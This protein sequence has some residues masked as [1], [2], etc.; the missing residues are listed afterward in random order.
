MS[1]VRQ[2]HK[3]RLGQQPEWA[4][5]EPNAVVS[6]TFISTLLKEDNAYSLLHRGYCLVE[7]SEETTACYS[8]F[9]G[10]IKQFF[11]AKDAE[12][13]KYAV[14]Q[15]DPA[16]GSPNQ[17]HGYSRVSTLKEQFMMRCIGTQIDDGYSFPSASFGRFGMQIYQILDLKSRALAKETLAMMGKC[18]KSVD[19]VLDP[20]HEI[21]PNLRDNIVE[22]ENGVFSK[23]VAD[24]YISSS[25]MDNFHYFPPSQAKHERFH[26]NHSSHTDSGLMTAVIVTD[27]PGLEVF[28]QRTSQWIAIE[29]EVIRHLKASGQLKEH[30]LC[31]RQYA[32]FF[33][34]D[35]VQYLNEAPYQ[36]GEER[37]SKTLKP[38]FHRV[39][40]CKQ[41]RYSVVF[42]QRT[43]PLRTHCRY[44]ED[45][46]LASIQQKVDTQS[47][48]AH[49]LWKQSNVEKA[50]GSRGYT[51]YLW[52]FAAFV[53]V[54]VMLLLTY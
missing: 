19:D 26:N 25:I 20:I 28:D 1:T 39:A 38:L 47:K 14:L 6:P 33:W 45:Y 53:S 42:K 16:L 23:F 30:P 24:G 5:K 40:D 10:L 29:E 41:E 2:A 3:F 52:A 46:V 7:L 18:P 8:K 11:A 50:V 54:C 51:G 22:S 36:E 35:S 12:K 31:H 15:F 34:S 17:C 49:A 9:H 4:G 48:N 32:T 44:Q 43:A 27:E 37:I 21:H 13:E